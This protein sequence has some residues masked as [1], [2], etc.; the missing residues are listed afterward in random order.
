MVLSG[1][2]ALLLLIATWVGYEVLVG[3]KRSPPDTA[4]FNSGR[5]RRQG[6]VL[7]ARQEGT[8]HLERK[9]AGAFLLTFG[10]NVRFAG[11]RTCG[12][13]AGTGRWPWGLGR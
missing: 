6:G 10:Q 2:G 3:N 13:Y 1:V 8:A 7:P 11:K 4:E 9:V 12:R 5:P